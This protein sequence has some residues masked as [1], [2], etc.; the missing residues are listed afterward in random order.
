KR[1]ISQAAYLKLLAPGLLPSGAARVI[2]LDADV[3]VQSD[4]QPLWAAPM[5][6]RLLLAVQDFGCPYVSCSFG[7]RRYR[8]LGLEA[9][10]PYFNSG[11]MLLDLERW[12]AE[13][14]ASRSLQYLDS[15]AAELRCHDQEALNAVAANRW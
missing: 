11:V 10:A 14:M 4:L 1:W 6:D 3:I 9:D 15:H 8:E 12:R 7:I 5:G 13:E 2:V